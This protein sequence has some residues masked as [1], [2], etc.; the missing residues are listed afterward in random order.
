MSKVLHYQADRIE[1]VLAS[2]KAPG[3]VTRLPAAYITEDEIRDMVEE[4]RNGLLLAAASDS[5]GV[6]WRGLALTRC[7]CSHLKPGKQD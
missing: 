5:G 7:V 2:Q 1:L 3:R 4:L 6:G